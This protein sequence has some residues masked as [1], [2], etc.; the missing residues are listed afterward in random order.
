MD[1]C[2]PRV[3]FQASKAK[4]QLPGTKL[5]SCPRRNSAPTR[6]E[7]AAAQCIV[8]IWNAEK[9]WN[10]CF[11]GTTFINLGICKSYCTDWIRFAECLDWKNPMN[12]ATLLD[13]LLPKGF[14]VMLAAPRFGEAVS[15]I[16]GLA[17]WLKKWNW[18]QTSQDFVFWQIWPK[19]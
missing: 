5:K 16:P 10:N 6:L 19:E 12:F 1:N 4:H 13:Y 15:Y 2:L 18:Q 9:S 11:W 14:G 8:E 17:A 7:L 3:F